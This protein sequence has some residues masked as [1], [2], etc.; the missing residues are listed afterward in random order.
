M[1]YKVF[2]KDEEVV[3]FEHITECFKYIDEML[4]VDQELKKE[5]FSIYHK[6][7]HTD[8]AI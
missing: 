3:E 2:Y 4:K 6:F 5:D 8:I 1:N 7:V